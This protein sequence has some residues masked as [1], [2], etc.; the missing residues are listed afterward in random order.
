MNRSFL[1]S[2]L[3]AVRS[4]I[5]DSARMDDARAQEALGDL[6]GAGGKFLRPRILILSAMTGSYDAERLRPLAAAVE[7]LHVATLI[8]DDVIDDAPSR[9]GI[10]ASHVR[11]GRKDAVLAGDFLFSRCFLLAADRTSPENARGLARAIALIVSA[12]IAQGADRWKFSPSVRSCVRKIGGKTAVL[13]SLAARAGAVESRAGNA[14]A[15]ALSRASWAAGVAFQ[16]Q[17]DILDWVG[18]ERALGKAVMNDLSE[19]LCTLPLAFALQSEERRLSPLLSSSAVASGSAAEVA[20][21]VRECGALG[22]ASEA[23]KSYRDRALG[24]LARLPSGF[25][26]DELSSLFSSFV[27]RV[28]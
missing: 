25:A 21:I 23:A 14:C 19:G 28:R 1:E 5:L 24:D 4:I 26:R 17:D 11:L 22:R 10:P 18:D 6:L 13:F 3:D 7:L 2:E 27:D 12:E 16:I 15:S 8:H 9:R 20:R